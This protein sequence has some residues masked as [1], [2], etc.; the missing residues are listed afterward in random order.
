[1]VNRFSTGFVACL[2]LVGCAGASYP[3][4]Y[5]GLAAAS[6]QGSLL[7]P[8]PKDDV[9]LMKCEPTAA[10]ARPCIVMF[11]DAFLRSKSDYLNQQ[12][13]I[14]DLER[15]LQQCGRKGD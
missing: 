14:I 2:F 9:D 7:G 15:Q 8:G 5:Y 4:K 6:F 13:R 3:Y 10:N 12:T 1:M 11:T